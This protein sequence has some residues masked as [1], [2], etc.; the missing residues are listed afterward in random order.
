MLLVHTAKEPW[1]I[2]H[3]QGRTPHI[4]AHS[5]GEQWSPCQL[6]AF[7]FI[8][9][10]KH[11]FLILFICTSSFCKLFIP[12]VHFLMR[13][14]PLSYCF[15]KKNLVNRPFL[16]SHFGGVVHRITAPAQDVHILTPRTCDCV[17][18][19]GKGDFADTIKNTNPEVGDHP[20]L[21][22]WSQSNHGYSNAEKLPGCGQREA[23]PQKVTQMQ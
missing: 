2:S 21:S 16:I 20:G 11:F 17:T 6:C 13:C 23:W 9:E 1:L 12:F 10:V 8:R 15:A 5:T 22:F 14:S 18:W 19:R 7:S 4:T 3:Q